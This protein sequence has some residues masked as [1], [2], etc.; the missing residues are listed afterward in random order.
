MLKGIV[1]FLVIIA[2]ISSIGLGISLIV[3]GIKL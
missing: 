3:I 2:I 1:I